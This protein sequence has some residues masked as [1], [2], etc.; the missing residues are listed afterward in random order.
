MGGKIERDR[1]ALLPGGEVASV[2]GVG[3]FG[4][5]EPGILPSGVSHGWA[6]PVGSAPAVFSNAIF[7]KFGMRLIGYHYSICDAWRSRFQSWSGCWWLTMPLS[8]SG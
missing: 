8:L 6:P 1:K 4:R 2:E 3:I 5:R 7:A